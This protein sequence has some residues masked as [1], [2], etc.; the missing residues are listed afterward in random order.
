M[1]P[2]NVRKAVVPHA[3]VTVA[4]VVEEA[5]EEAAEEVELPEEVV[6]DSIQPEVA[7]V[8]VDEVV[9]MSMGLDKDSAEAEDSAVNMGESSKKVLEPEDMV[10]A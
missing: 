9:D 8:F 1:D 4:A 2:D 6:E 5:A 10:G 3:V 7:L